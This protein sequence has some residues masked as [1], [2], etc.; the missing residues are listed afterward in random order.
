MSSSTP[1]FLYI[2]E[3]KT[4]ATHRGRSSIPGGET[5]EELKL[6]KGF[7]VINRFFK[8]GLQSI[9]VICFDTEIKGSVLSLEKA[10]TQVKVT[11]RGGTDFK[12][13]IEYIDEHRKYDGLIIFTDGYAAIPPKPKNRKT[14]ILWL[15]NTESNWQEIHKEL[16][17]IGRSV[18]L[19]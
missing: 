6:A 18:F 4:F 16:K 8:Y 17:H 1:S 19:N 13:V 2:L 11:G 12:P 5:S 15:F 10:Q 3:T 9:D 14:R 7:S